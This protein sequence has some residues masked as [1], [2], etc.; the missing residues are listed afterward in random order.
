M[1]TVCPSGQKSGGN[2]LVILALTSSFCALVYDDR[3]G[4]LQT[5]LRGSLSNR[6]LLGCDRRRQDAE[7]KG[8]GGERSQFCFR[9]INITAPDVAPSPAVAL[10]AVVAFHTVVAV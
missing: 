8:G 5:R 4:I 9:D 10:H 3:A 7:P 6:L 2:L 1:G